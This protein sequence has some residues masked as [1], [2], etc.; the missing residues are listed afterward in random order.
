MVVQFPERVGDSMSMRVYV[1]TWDAPPNKMLV[2][3]RG[4]PRQK[5]HT[6]TYPLVVLYD[7]NFDR[8]RAASSIKGGVELRGSIEIA[9]I[10]PQLESC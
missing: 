10:G 1:K 4:N 5:V 7:G 2:S 8:H 3:L 9:Q 6:N